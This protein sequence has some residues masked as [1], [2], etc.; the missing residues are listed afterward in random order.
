MISYRDWAKMAVAAM[1]LF[2]F[3]FSAPAGE[4]VKTEKIKPLASWDGIQLRIKEKDAWNDLRFGTLEAHANCM[5]HRGRKVTTIPWNRMERAKIHPW[6]IR[7]EIELGSPDGEMVLG[8]LMN[9]SRYDFEMVFRDLMRFRD[10]ALAAEEKLKKPKGE[11]DKDT[12]R[13]ENQ[14]ET[15]EK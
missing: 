5:I 4:D 2:M 8:T 1:I 10:K 12:S 6:D 9:W 15:G 3:P 14:L 7:I 11:Q 13:D